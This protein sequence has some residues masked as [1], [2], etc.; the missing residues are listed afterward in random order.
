MTERT[1]RAPTFLEALI[2]VAFSVTVIGAGVLLWKV[3]V[4][5]PVLLATV[6]AAAVGY[7]VLRRPWAVIEEGIVGGITM[8]MTAILIMYTIGLVVGSWIQGGIVPSMIYYG[9][10]ILSPR[11]FL[12]STLLICSIVSLATGSSWGTSGTVG[13]A[14]IGIAA[15]LKIPTPLAAGII[16]SGAYLGDKMSPLSDTTNLAPAVAGADLFQHIRAMLWTTGP[17]Y[18]IV[19]IL[20][21][22]LGMRFAGGTLEVER[23]QAIQAVMAREFHVS[24][25]G[26]LPPVLVIALVAMKIP[27]LPGLMAGVLAG[28][29]MALLQGVGIAD[30]LNVLQNG[31]SPALS[32][33]LADASDTAAALKVLGE[34]NLSIRPDLAKEVGGMLKD[35]LARGGLQAMNWTVSLSFCA[36]AFGGVM[37]KCGFLDVILEKVL[38]RVRT[39]GGLVTAVILSSVSCN[40]LLGDQ[41]LAIV[42]P[43]RMYKTTFAQK[44]LHP[45]MLSR[46]LEDAG[47]ITSVLVPWNSCGAYHAGL[48]GVPTLEYLPYAFLNWMNPIVSILTAY[49]GIGIAWLGK[50]GEPVLGRRRPDEA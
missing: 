17:T 14:L 50:R 38:A 32:A 41:Y 6:F 33:A 12:V 35:L 36:L 31:Y 20:A 11:V 13:I 7:F 18:V 39:V 45:R 21:L 40:I 43:G 23:I 4:H 10:S 37:E 1:G 30:M 15:G 3:D 8:A 42:I 49:L 44:G 16:I 2:V 46:C 28:S 27:A 48:F 22:A 25:W 29:A 24:P 26:L 5:I 9:L 34:N 47:T 19:L